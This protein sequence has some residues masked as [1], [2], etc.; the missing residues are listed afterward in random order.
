MLTLMQIAAL[1]V[2]GMCHALLGSVK[3]PL[4]RKLQIDE[5]RVGGLV[6]VFGFTLIPMVLA[7]GFLVDS[8]GKQAVLS[9]GF[10][11]LIVSLLILAS[12]RSYGTALFAV[13]VPELCQTIRRG[14]P[15]Y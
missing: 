12:L 15:P 6:S 5:G 9:A 13:L 7:A 10:V 1:A 2:A 11:L 8:L 4:A 14:S 3:V